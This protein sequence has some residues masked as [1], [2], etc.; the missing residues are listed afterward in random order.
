[1]RISLFPI[2]LLLAFTLR[3]QEWKLIQS[4]RFD[5]R[6]TALS[7]DQQ[8]NIYIGTDHGLIKKYDQKG[9]YVTD[10]ELPSTN[11]ITLLEAVNPLRLFVFYGQNQEFTYFERFVTNATTYHL[12][13][14]SAELVRMATVGMDHSMW[15]LEEPQFVL[16]KIN[17]SSQ[18]VLLSAP[19]NES[20]DLPDLRYMKSHRDLFLLVDHEIGI[21]ILDQFANRIRLIPQSGVRFVQVVD[22]KITFISGDQLLSIGIYDSNEN[23]WT[24][25]GD[26]SRVLISGTSY[27]FFSNRKMDIYQFGPR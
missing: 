12:R 26:Y 2:L 4:T 6:I 15:I 3:A 20:I 5:Q 22:E 25:P 13:Q 19:L 14:Y 1:M 8:Q 24:I 7:I 21:Y 10:I 16:K 17:E 9:T 11:E 27:Y 18:Q 23:V